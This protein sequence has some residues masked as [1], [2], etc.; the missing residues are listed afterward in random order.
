MR[1]WG[2]RWGYWDIGKYRE[3]TR[4][5]TRT[6][7]V[8]ASRGPKDPRD[9]VQRTKGPKTQGSKDLEG[10]RVQRS[11]GP[12]VQGSRGQGVHG[13]RVK[14]PKGQGTGSKGPRVQRFKAPKV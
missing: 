8:P 5:S 4:G 13:P 7:E 9:W 12:R 2:G 10:P 1:R 14:G 3:G 11:K 6:D